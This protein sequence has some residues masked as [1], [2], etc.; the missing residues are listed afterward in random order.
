MLVLRA[1]RIGKEIQGRW[2]FSHVSLEIHVGDRVALIGRNGV[3]KTTLLNCLMGRSTVDAG[4]IHRRIPLSDYGLMEQQVEVA[5]SASL[6]DLVLSADPGLYAVKRQLTRLENELSGPATNERSLRAYA[7]LQDQ[8]LAHDGYSKEADIGN[9]LRRLQFSESFWEQPY[10]SL[11][12]GEKTRAQL[13]RLMAAQPQFLLLDEPT[14]HLDAE[15]LDWLEDFIRQYRG[16]ILFVSH[17][18]RFIDAVATST[19][20]L[21]RE[22]VQGARGGYC[23]YRAQQDLLQRSQQALYD[24]QERERRELLA[25]IQQYREWFQKAHDAASERD[26]FAKKRAAKNAK[27][28]QAKERALQHLEERRVAKPIQ[29]AHARLDFQDGQF[30]A[31]NLVTLHDVSFSYGPRAVLTHLNLTV[32]RG[33]RI[34]VVGRNGA[35]KSTLLKL[36]VGDLAP[37]IGRSTRHPALRV[38]YFAQEVDALPRSQSILSSMLE[39]P[40]ITQALART[41]LAG[42]LFPSEDVYKTI[43]DLSMGEQCRVAFVRLYFSKANLLVL[44]EPANYLDIDTRERMEEALTAYPGSVV[45]VSHDRCLVSKVSNR[46]WAIDDGT[47]TDF[48]GAYEEY[49]ER[50]ATGSRRNTDPERDN[51]IRRLQLELTQQLSREE[52]TEERDRLQLR[53]DIREL[54]RR[55]DEWMARA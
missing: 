54:K 37:D 32:E 20:E 24:K 52:P 22:G 10:Q 50:V 16:T 1:D 39:L 34:A 41:I 6:L 13:A 27:R 8:Y 43:G 4:L 51:E 2:I 44:D 47:V 53:E 25:A 17:D 28:F 29:E 5:D 15:T 11:S 49:R 33:D 35:G 36:L 9:V 18:R 30:D 7:E 40:G 46:I 21:R 38:G 3:G 45:M 55:L 42:F 31:R 14:N 12:G 26:P 48:H 19:C 23:A